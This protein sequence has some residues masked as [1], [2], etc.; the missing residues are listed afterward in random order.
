M[1]DKSNLRFIELLDKYK[2]LD[3]LYYDD[4]FY[5][6]NKKLWEGKERDLVKGVLKC[7]IEEFT[8]KVEIEK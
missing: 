2:M 4:F 7:A 8:I 3:E 6:K 5:I 1:S